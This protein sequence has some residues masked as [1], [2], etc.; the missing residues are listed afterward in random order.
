[1]ALGSAT[2][3]RLSLDAPVSRAVKGLNPALGRVTLRQL[4]SHTAGMREASP[5]VVSR[6]DEALGRMVRGWKADYLFAPP[7]DVFSYSG[8]GYW[9]A[10]YVLESVHGQP[11][12][13]LVRTRLFL[14]LGMARSTL[15][16]LEALT[17]DFAQGHEEAGGKLGVVRPMA[18]NTAMYPAGSVF[19]SARELAR[20]A[21]V[22]L[23][24]GRDGER[25]LLA[26]QSVRQLFSAH[27][28]LPG[29]DEARYGFGLVELKVGALTA[30]EHGGVRRGYGSHLRFLP[31][32]R[33]A[34]ILLT[35]RNGATLR[36]SLDLIT[37]TVWN[38][39][40]EPEQTPPALPLTASDAKRYTGTYA[41]ADLARFTVRWQGGQL[42]VVSGEADQVLERVG[43]HLFR[44][45]EGGEY[46]FVV[47]PGAPR[48]RYL[49]TDLLTA[50]RVGAP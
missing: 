7:G 43:E 35:N 14:P 34:V 20:L 11:Y 41:H 27:V 17:Y 8:P 18:E 16:P 28:A 47:K 9:L 29:T 25:Q 32:P 22:L 44:T 45:K 23:A 37:R 33:G 2:Q 6:D 31:R 48:A 21:T 39:P 24:G 10:G 40:E 30:Y 12:A 3:G 50:A 49:H 42:R 13:E 4:L 36:R 1:M 15:R 46:A 38:L 19:S 5:S 26:E